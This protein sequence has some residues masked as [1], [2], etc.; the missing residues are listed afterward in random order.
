MHKKIKAFFKH[1]T[2]AI[3]KMMAWTTTR[4]AS[5]PDSYFG[6]KSPTQLDVTMAGVIT[7]HGCGDV[8]AFKIFTDAII[9]SLRVQNHPN[10]LAYVAAA[11]T[12]SS[13]GFDAVI[14]ATGVF[15]GTWEGGSGAIHAENQAL[16]WLAGL[17]GLPD[18]SG[19]VFVAG[20]TMG[21]LSALHAAR[22]WRMAKLGKR[23]QRW[24]MLASEQVHSSIQLAANV[25][26]VELV[27]VAT[28]ENGVMCADDAR[29]AI[30]DP[31]R[32]FAII[33]NAGATNCGAIDDLRGLGELAQQLG[34]WLH[35]DGALGLG[36][37]CN[38]KARQDFDGL[39]LADSFIIDPPKWLF[40]PYDCC[41][42]IY[43]NPTDAVMAHSQTAVYLDN[44]AD[45]VWN[46]AQYAIHLSRRARGLPF[47]FSLVSNG[48]E[49]Y[50]QAIAACI[51]TA[52][53]IAD[54][55]DAS[56]KFDLLVRSKLSVLLF[57]PTNIS[58][59]QLDEWAEHARADGTIYCLPTQWRGQKALRI[60]VV[61]PHTDANEVIRILQESF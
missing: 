34:L 15:A 28:D 39:A 23:P 1:D 48:T 10:N 31:T 57:R 47:W 21:N 45:D 11:P 46:P 33:A 32:F 54:W 9:P 24:A 42:L 61:N 60:C 52:H 19:G 8:A 35:V 26:D 55:L 44:I 12:P 17:A 56:A 49:A 27:L 38:A 16:A 4:I 41:A 59:A 7:E 51:D 36:A 5:Q 53:Q 50:S 22:H 18:S 13:L 40:T 30:D 2:D 29:Q 25:M 58:D 20:G 43:K 37:L 14:G 3:D 6:A